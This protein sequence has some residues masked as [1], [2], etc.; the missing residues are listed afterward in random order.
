MELFLNDDTGP[1]A[2]DRRTTFQY[3]SNHKCAIRCSLN[4]VDTTAIELQPIAQSD[5]VCSC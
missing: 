1:K 5:L 4:A 3:Q 2:L